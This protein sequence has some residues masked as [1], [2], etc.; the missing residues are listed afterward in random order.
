MLSALETSGS[1][2]KFHKKLPQVILALLQAWPAAAATEW[3][4]WLSG[5]VQCVGFLITW[6]PRTSLEPHHSSWFVMICLIFVGSWHVGYLVLSL[7][8]IE[9]LISNHS[10]DKKPAGSNHQSTSL[11]IGLPPVVISTLHLH[12]LPLGQPKSVRSIYSKNLSWHCFMTIVSWLLFLWL[13][14]QLFQLFN[15]TI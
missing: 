9:W 1:C 14:F 8:L 5:F 11:D 6:I 4:W 10:N 3:F 7:S 15:M 13:L 12:H 2:Y